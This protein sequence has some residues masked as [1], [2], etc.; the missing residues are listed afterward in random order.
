[1]AVDKQ[2]TTITFNAAADLSASQFRVARITAANAVNVAGAV[3]D[4]IGI[5]QDKP[6][7]GQA[8][9]VRTDGVSK[10]AYGATVAAGAAVTCDGTGR[11]ITAATGRQILGYA[12]SGGVANEIGTVLISIRGLQP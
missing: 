10:A 5:I 4:I 3:N 9:A 8:C 12:V 2:G 7:L 1:M 11:I 6:L